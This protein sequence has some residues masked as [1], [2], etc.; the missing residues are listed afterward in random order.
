MPWNKINTPF[1]SFYDDADP[2]CIH[3]IK[4]GFK[5]EYLVVKED[6]FD[7]DTGDTDRLTSEGIKDRYGIDVAEF[8]T[9]PKTEQA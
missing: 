8:L 9:E 4:L 6:A 1:V 7:I 3:I 5:N 2:R